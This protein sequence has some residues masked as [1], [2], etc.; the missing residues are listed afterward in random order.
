[1]QYIGPS[2]ILLLGIAHYHEPFARTQVVTF[3]LIWSALALY[4]Y[5]ALRFYRQN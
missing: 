3:A 1:M 4:S 5:D 2:C